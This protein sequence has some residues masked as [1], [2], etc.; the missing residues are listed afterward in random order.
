MSST[1]ENKT[2][3]SVIEY[4]TENGDEIKLSSEIVKNFLVKGGGAVTNQEIFGFI[5]LCRYQKINPF[6]NEAY[7][8]KFGNDVQI[9]AGKELFMKRAERNPQYLGFEAGIIILTKDGKVEKREGTF[10]IKENGEKTVGGWA[11][12]YRKDREKP[13]VS[14]VSFSEYNKGTAT[15]NSKPTTMIR[16]VALVQ[17]LREAF[18][19]SL[20]GLYDE[21]EYN[22]RFK[23]DADNSAGCADNSKL[24]DI[25]AALSA[26]P[27]VPETKS[28]VIS[29]EFRGSAPPEYQDNFADL[30][31]S[32]VNLPF[33]PP[34]EPPEDGEDAASLFGEGA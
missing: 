31:E 14:E 18:P 1:A 25:N 32:D 7:L 5:N 20:G 23:A 13:I 9:V 12:V 3:V 22:G 16:K 33:A 6:L 2:G 11:K 17:A 26:D 29:V 27:V 8:I 4:K 15:W 10:I 24:R 19:D 21:D 30:P 28:D 34:P